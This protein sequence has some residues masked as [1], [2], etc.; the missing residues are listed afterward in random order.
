[1]EVY[2]QC[3]GDKEEMV[4]GVNRFYTSS[5][6][7]TNFG[8]KAGSFN[9]PQF[10]DIIYQADG[11]AR[12]FL[13]RAIV[14]GSAAAMPVKTP[15]SLCRAEKKADNTGCQHSLV[16]HR[17][18]STDC[19]HSTASPACLLHSCL[20]MSIKTMPVLLQTHSPSW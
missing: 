9:L 8:G 17:L 7:S 13:T 2:R 6:E 3:S 18:L 19:Y 16:T 20:T 4:Q 11:R 1:M 5:Q 14:S 15:P 10:Y 12:L